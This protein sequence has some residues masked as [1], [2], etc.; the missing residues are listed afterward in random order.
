MLFRVAPF[1]ILCAFSCPVP[2]ALRARE[3]SG[4][5]SHSGGTASS[6]GCLLLVPFLLFPDH[7]LCWWPL[8]FSYSPLTM[9]FRSRRTVSNDPATSNA[10]PPTT[11]VKVVPGSLG[12]TWKYWDFHV[13]VLIE[14]SS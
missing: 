1:L 6:R 11:I 8:L 5:S 10:D 3:V 13:S 14:G 9:N 2:A 12:E 4:A 7:I